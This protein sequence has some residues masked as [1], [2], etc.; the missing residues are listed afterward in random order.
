MD[1]S[2]RALTDRERSHHL[3]TVWMVLSRTTRSCTGVGSQRRLAQD[4]AALGRVISGR[5]RG[6]Q[7]ECSQGCDFVGLTV[8]LE[9]HFAWFVPPSKNQETTCKTV[10]ISRFC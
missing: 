4:P 3:G 10:Q 5:S 7:S 9:E 2:A 1:P 8:F 6:P